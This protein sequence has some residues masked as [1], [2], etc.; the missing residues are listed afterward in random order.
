LEDAGVGELMVSENLYAIGPRTRLAP[1]LAVILGDR[2]AELRDAKVIPVI[3]EIVVEILSP[4]ERP[5]RVNRKLSQYFAAGVREVWLIDPESR[6]AEIW[7]GPT[8]PQHLLAAEDS[9]TS[10]LLPGFSVPLSGLFS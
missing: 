8:L 4:S 10:P 2:S 7:T 3:P 5:G 9:L 1:D 6:S